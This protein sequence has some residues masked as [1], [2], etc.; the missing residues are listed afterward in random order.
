MA[1]VLQN[2]PLSKRI[3]ATSN[4]PLT[5]N[6]EISGL[7]D[8]SS[9]IAVHCISVEGGFRYIT[10]YVPGSYK[11]YKEPTT[12]IIPNGYKAEF[13]NFNINNTMAFAKP[14]SLGY[15]SYTF[16]DNIT[17]ALVEIVKI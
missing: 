5:D 15:V 11:N 6:K 12:Y 1:K 10:L 9:P 8:G 14:D 4:A 3:F 2:M 17:V 16:I 7:P 13:K